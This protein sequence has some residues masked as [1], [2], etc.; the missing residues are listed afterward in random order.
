[1]SRSRRTNSIAEATSSPSAAFCEP[2][3]EPDHR[4][5]CSAFDQPVFHLEKRSRES[6][7]TRI[8]DPTRCEPAERSDE[9]I[10]SRES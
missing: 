8:L 2:F 4:L 5:V 1:M 6:H 7:V 10:L 9:R 3:D